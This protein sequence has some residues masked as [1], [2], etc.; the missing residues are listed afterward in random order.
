M[1]NIIK[2]SLLVM[3]VFAL[4]LGLGFNTPANAVPT[5][6]ARGLNAPAFNN[7]W[8][9]PARPTSFG[10]PKITEVDVTCTTAR[11]MWKDGKWTFVDGT[12]CPLNQGFTV[13][14]EGKNLLTW[15]GS[16]PKLAVYDEDKTCL[17]SDHVTGMG[18]SY[19]K[20]D[21]NGIPK[22]GSYKVYLE[23]WHTDAVDTN[24]GLKF[25]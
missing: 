13:E 20:Y 25:G 1:K 24:L 11:E 22:A 16:A 23:Y 14:V 5:A 8:I 7:G 17:Y 2:K 15:T 21:F 19:L 9:S 18:E 12:K 3:S 4:V 10:R 6:P